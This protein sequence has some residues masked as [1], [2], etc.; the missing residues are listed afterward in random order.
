VGLI[1]YDH[2]YPEPLHAIRPIMSSFAAALVL[3]PEVGPHAMAAIDIEL[4]RSAGKDTPMGDPG[5]EALRMGVPAA[6]CLPL[7]RALARAE[8]A[9]IEID[10]IP[11]AHLE[12][13]VS[14]CR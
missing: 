6:R 10:Y 8:A 9:R 4:V 14:P 13:R 5:L 3:A 1:A 11:G 2:P 7:L 12:L